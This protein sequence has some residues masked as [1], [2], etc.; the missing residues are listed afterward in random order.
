MRK[1]L[2]MIVISTQVLFVFSQKS[3]IEISKPIIDSTAITNW[4]GVG[5]SG[6]VLIS[7]NG[8]YFSYILNRG[9]RSKRIIQPLSGK[10]KVFS[11]VNAE[12][13]LF[14]SDSKHFIYFSKDTIVNLDLEND[15][16]QKVGGISAIIKPKKNSGEIIAYQLKGSK[17]ELVIEYISENRKIHFDSVSSCTFDDTGEKMVLKMAVAPDSPYASFKWLNLRTGAIHNIGLVRAGENIENF[18]FDAT[19]NKVAFITK[20]LYDSKSVFSLWLFDAIRNET[21]IKATNS[22]GGIKNGECISRGTPLFTKDGQYIFFQVEKVIL[23]KKDPDYVKVDVWNYQDNELQSAQLYKQKPLNYTFSVS[24]NTNKIVRLEDDSEVLV[25]PPRKIAGGY[26]LVA[27]DHGDR[28]WELKRGDSCNNEN[29]LVS[30]EDGSRS[31]I[32]INGLTKYYYSPDG[33]YIIYHNYVNKRFDYYSYNLRSGRSINI[34]AGMP[35]NWLMYSDGSKYG[36]VD[37]ETS[38]IGL[39]GWSKGED[40]IFVYDNFDFWRLSLSGEKA[41]VNITG[42]YGRKHNT[43][44]RLT[45]ETDDDKCYNDGDTLLLTAFNWDNKYNGFYRKI[46]SERGDPDSLSMRP[47]SI[48]LYGDR[49]LPINDQIKD[50]GMIPL[51]ARDTAVWV[52]QCNTINDASN[53]FFTN[54][55]VRYERITN[56]QPQLEYNWYTTELVQW[57]QYDGKFTRGILYKPE[58]FDQNKKYPVIIFHYRQLSQRLYNYLCPYWSGGPINI[59]WFV[60]RGYIVL[61]PDIFL[62]EKGSGPSAYNAVASAAEWLGRQSFID[63]SRIGLSGHSR[64]G[65]QTNY[66]IAHTSLFAAALPGAGGADAITSAFSLTGQRESRLEASEGGLSNNLWKIPEVYL[67][68]SPLLRADRI[69][70]PVLIFHCEAD[71]GVPWELSLQLFTALRRL[72]KP[73]WMLQYD[74]GGHVLRFT[75][76]M[77]DFT[78]RSTQFFDYFLKDALPPRWMTK[79]VPAR[80]KGIETGLELEESKK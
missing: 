2:L 30:L 63:K 42:G 52:V 41:P 47:W 14:S 16:E 77:R 28:F 50:K 27:K 46:L 59:P 31:L 48:C 70:T 45:Y 39:A 22:A 25:V 38:P 79:G 4:I 78:I 75:K 55:F 57:K 67:E 34:S 20:R 15:S 68:N 33:H 58:N 12:N 24:V 80:L 29:W 37:D 64:A 5:Y 62:T 40:A 44:L 74:D 71:G 60:S 21:I 61:T 9:I 11:L 54:D 72:Q 35:R 32:K 1:L 69:T 49:L 3:R 18:T 73:V 26:A 65:F 13:G 7:N 56:F 17:K 53:Y 36:Q 19:G 76:D 10:S 43:R 66:I 51:R 6:D 23:D 8:R